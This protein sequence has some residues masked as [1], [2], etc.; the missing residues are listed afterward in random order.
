MNG[1]LKLQN[2][3]IILNYLRFLVSAAYTFWQSDGSA[4]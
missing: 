3:Q 4:S 2:S 1:I